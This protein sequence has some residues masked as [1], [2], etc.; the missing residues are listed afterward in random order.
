M[1]V[2]KNP[3]HAESWTSVL[4]AAKAVVVDD[5]PSSSGTATRKSHHEP[6]SSSETGVATAGKASNSVEFII[7]DSTCPPT[8][9][10]KAQQ[11]RIPVV[12]SEYVVQC[13]INGRR[14]SCAAH[15][16]FGVGHK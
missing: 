14:L 9:V 10:K 16:K 7:S 6:D 11:M 4:T 13:L 5:F 1:L 2:S 8:V 12:S 15:E 3:R